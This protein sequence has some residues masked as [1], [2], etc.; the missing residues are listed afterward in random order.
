[1]FTNAI[2]F[3]AYAITVKLKYNIQ[4]FLQLP[5]LDVFW[6]CLTVLELNHFNF[7]AEFIGGAHQLLYLFIDL[8]L[9]FAKG[10]QL[11]VVG[12]YYFSLYW[13]SHGWLFLGDPLEIRRLQLF[14]KVDHALL[15]DVCQIEERVAVDEA[16][17]VPCVSIGEEKIGDI[18]LNEVERD[19]RSEGCLLGERVEANWGHLR[20]FFSWE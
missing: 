20:I 3:A 18:V 8:S 9:F 19:D 12:M 14:W 4:H 1:M 11:M 16:L 17:I 7:F 10:C 6:R 2:L 13:F 5:H 15:V